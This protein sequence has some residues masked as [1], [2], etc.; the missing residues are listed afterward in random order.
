MAQVTINTELCKGCGLCV[1]ACP[2]KIMR[3]SESV[4]NKKGVHPAEIADQAACTACTFCAVLCPD[5][6]IHIEK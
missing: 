4:I 2:K 3:L 6:V 1:A 5:V